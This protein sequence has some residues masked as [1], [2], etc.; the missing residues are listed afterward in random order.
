MK[1]IF[2][3]WISLMVLLFMCNNS[4]AQ[5]TMKD[6]KPLQALTGSWKMVIKMGSAFYEHWYRVNDSLL[7][8]KSYG[9]N[10]RDTISQET[11]QLKL[12][13]GIITYTSTVADQNN[14]QPVTFTLVKLENGKYI[15]ENK[16]HDFPQ[17]ITYLLIDKNTL[18]ASISG[19]RK[20]K[21]REVLFNFKREE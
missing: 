12:T 2:R 6:F 1:N 14:Q 16:A 7:Q 15:F 5:Y 13:H 3:R 11:V 20:D 17:Q 9:I 18:H 4:Y 19:T 10:R 21:F 8:N